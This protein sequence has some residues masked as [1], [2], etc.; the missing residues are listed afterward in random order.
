[1]SNNTMMTK[2]IIYMTSLLF[3][4][5][6]VIISCSTWEEYERPAHESTA[7]LL[8]ADLALQYIRDIDPAFNSKGRM[9][10]CAYVSKHANYNQLYVMFRRAVGFSDYYVIVSAN[11]LGTK[12]SP[13]NA[14]L[15]Y[16]FDEYEEAEKF[17]EALIS[18][19][20]RHR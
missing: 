7:S 11:R 14:D 9:F 2:V 10:P 15:D 19:G 16:Q 4:C 18:L 1:M 17:Y 12:S 8:P 3:I 20:V 6:L 5:S 13:C